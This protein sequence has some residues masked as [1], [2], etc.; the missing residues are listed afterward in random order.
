[1]EFDQA[2]VDWDEIREYARVAVQMLSKFGDPEQLAAN[3]NAFIDETI[4]EMRKADAKPAVASVAAPTAN[5]QR[6]QPRA[7][8]PSACA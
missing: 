3:A 6:S 8:R 7:P 1:M 5:A 4:E 2:S